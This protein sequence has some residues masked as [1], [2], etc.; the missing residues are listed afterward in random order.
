MKGIVFSYFFPPLNSSEGNVTFKLINASKNDHDVFYQNQL[1]LW[2]YGKNNSLRSDCIKLIPS[3][4]GSLD[5]FR[6]KGI[7]TFTDEKLNEYDYIM[8]RSMPGE[9]H[10]IALALKKR[11]PGKFWLASFGDPIANNP[12]EKFVYEHTM[13]PSIRTFHGM[14]AAVKYYGTKNV[15]KKRNQKL[16][17]LQNNIF[18]YADRLIFNSDY[19]R[20]YMLGDRYDELISKTVIL[21]HPYDA[22]LFHSRYDEI[23]LKKEATE[24][25]NDK[26]QILFAGH[27]DSLRSL[28]M[29]L[30]ALESQKELF[31][32]KLEF[33]ILGNL[34]QADRDY[35]TYADLSSIVTYGKQ[36]SYEK[37]LR[38][39][40]EADLL[41][42]VDAV[43]PEVLLKENIFF[44]AKIADYL[45]SGTKI[46][47]LTT[48]GISKKILEENGQYCLINNQSL[49]V[50][51]LYDVTTGKVD[52]SKNETLPPE[53]D[54]RNVAKI[55][56]DILDKEVK[57]EI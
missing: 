28:R 27:T 44:A 40:K 1:E 43:F 56:D 52:L 12:Y 41:I 32:E 54:A 5:E 38:A 29:F 25:K 57:G 31:E 4:S 16:I 23:V 13:R 10:E 2:S 45:G 6:D 8:S 36:V 11:N 35:I 47:G 21:P 30:E 53:Y 18:T 3:N 42:H 20:T 19:Q 24:K 9:S 17:E 34:P 48:E 39:M 26:I 49:I 33:T 7:A 37:S 46:L 51:F 14:K 15:Y 50:N 22:S 55:Y